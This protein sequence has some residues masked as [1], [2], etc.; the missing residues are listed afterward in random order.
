MFVHLRN[1]ARK[2][3]VEQDVSVIDA[4]W[5]NDMQPA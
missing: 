3:A 1:S 2:V 5:I 4:F